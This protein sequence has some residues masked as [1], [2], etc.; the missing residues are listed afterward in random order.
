[1]HRAH[2]FQNKHNGAP[3]PA[4]AFL[5]PANAIH[6]QYEALRAY[7]VEKVP[8][9][10]VARRFGFSKASF[11]NMVR[12]FR[13]DPSRALFLLPFKDSSH[14]PQSDPLGNPRAETRAPSACP[15]IYDTV[16]HKGQQPIL[17]PA[18][19]KDIVCLQQ[20]MVPARGAQA[21]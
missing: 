20:G 21:G 4:Q 16:R 19:L 10:E 8:V 5:C 11:Q 1:M 15:S 7:F 9:K 17:T 6:R 13:K 2:V 3:D 18:A 12:D 14:A